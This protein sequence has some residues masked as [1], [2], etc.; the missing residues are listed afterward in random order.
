MVAAFFMCYFF[1]KYTYFLKTKTLNVIKQDNPF[2]KSQMMRGVIWVV[3]ILKYFITAHRFIPA[4]FFILSWSI[5]FAVEMKHSLSSSSS[6]LLL[7]LLLLLFTFQF[8]DENLEGD[9]SNE[10]YWILTFKEI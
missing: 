1:T 2:N 3:F 8:V 9:H 10:S 4:V 5:F 7:L 6:S